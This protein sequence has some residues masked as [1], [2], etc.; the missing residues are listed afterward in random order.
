MSEYK[1][2]KKIQKKFFYY[3]K[4]KAVDWVKTHPL[5]SLENFNNSNIL[6][7]IKK[8]SVIDDGVEFDMILANQENDVDCKERCKRWTLV[9]TTQSNFP[10]S[11]HIVTDSEM[12][13]HYYL[14]SN[15]QEF[16]W[17]NRKKDYYKRIKFHNDRVIKLL[18][19]IF[20]LEY[21]RNNNVFYILDYKRILNEISKE[22]KNGS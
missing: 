20:G 5:E 16:K 2:R 22:T 8:D 12:S 4:N 15:N 19:C 14:Y 1:V 13:Y 10:V 18:K 21:N 6:I 11:L 7:E 17:I 9:L 3:F